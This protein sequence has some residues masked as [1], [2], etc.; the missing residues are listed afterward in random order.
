M[1]A[2]TKRFLQEHEDLT[3]ENKVIN[4]SNRHTDISHTGN[5][6]SS[7]QIEKQAPFK[8]QANRADLSPF[9]GG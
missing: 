5:E 3:R 2:E 6:F 9:L 4:A 1:D 8:Y 7:S